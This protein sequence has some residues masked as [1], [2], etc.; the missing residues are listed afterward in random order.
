MAKPLPKRIVESPV[1]IWVGRRDTPAFRELIA[2][3]D[4]EALELYRNDKPSRPRSRYVLRILAGLT[5]ESRRAAWRKGH[6]HFE[7]AALRAA[8]DKAAMKM[9]EGQG[10]K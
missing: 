6:Q 10:R 8:L 1:Q 5:P 4:G 7:D 2:E 9:R 3:I